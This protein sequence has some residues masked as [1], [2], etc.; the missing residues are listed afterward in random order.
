MGKSR[1][2]Y[3]RVFCL[4]HSPPLSW[5]PCSPH[6][7]Q[8][9]TPCSHLSPQGYSFH[10]VLLAQLRYTHREPV[11]GIG[12]R[13]VTKKSKIPV[14]TELT[15]RWYFWP[16]YM[17][18][19]LCV[20][21]CVRFFATPWTAAEQAPLSMEFSRQEYWSGLPFPTRGDLPDPGIK[22][23]SLTSP[24]LAGRFF[25][26]APPGKPLVCAFFAF[27][28]TS[29]P[30]SVRQSLFYTL[31]CTL[32]FPL[33]PDSAAAAVAAKLLQSRPTLCDPIDGSPPGYPSLGFSRQEHWSGLPFPP[34]MHESEKWKWSHS[35]VS[36][37]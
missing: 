17:Q 33:N 34:P 8:P 11:L 27:V 37:S 24:A 23:V 4:L 30:A 26:L 6:Q 1:T 15:Y 3:R 13:A 5:H 9:P 36:D 14:L 32:L 16:L 12:D 21:R 29:T 2:Q 10:F 19:G 7:R 20:F 35:V 31:S 28:T 25:T 18:R 22:P